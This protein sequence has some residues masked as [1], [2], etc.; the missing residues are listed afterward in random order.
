MT[1]DMPV[2][3]LGPWRDTEE[4]YREERGQRVGVIWVKLIY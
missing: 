3:V 1:L 2:T 4:E